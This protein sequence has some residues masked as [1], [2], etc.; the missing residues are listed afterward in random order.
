VSG[1]GISEDV[2]TRVLVVLAHPDDPEFFCGG[3]VARWTNEGLS[4]T[5][6]LLTK[7]ERGDDH[8]GTD[9]EAL[10]FQRMEE[11][12]RAASVLGVQDIIFLDHPDGYLTP[13]LALRKD[14]VRVIRKVKPEIVITCDPT[15]FFPSDRYINHPDHRAAGQATLDAVFPAAGSGLFFP[16]LNDE[17]GL[18]PHKVSQVF[19]AGAQHP[20][21]VVEV[22]DYINRKIEA[23]RE[24]KSQIADMDGLEKRVLKNL[25][26]EESPPEAP[27]YIEKY[28]K[29]DLR[30]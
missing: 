11:Q 26:D 29:I 7:G 21:T 19:V 22:T 9:P 8:T 6:C 10:A 1:T 23:L 5:Y 12:R 4:V 18:V 15:N 2:P 13:D 28:K 27:R 14:V 25:L 3:T 24:H 16:E 17:E 20:N 30:R